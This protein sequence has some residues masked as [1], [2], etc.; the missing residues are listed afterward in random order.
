MTNCNTRG[1][2]TELRFLCIQGLGHS[3]GLSP[4]IREQECLSPK[5]AKPPLRLCV[6][7]N[8][9]FAVDDPGVEISWVTVHL[10][11]LNRYKGTKAH[12]VDCLIA[13]TA[14]AQNVPSRPLIRTF[15]SLATCAWKPNSCKRIAT[16]ARYRK[17]T[18]TFPHSIPNL[19]AKQ[20]KNLQGNLQKH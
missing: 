19:P 3:K 15:E 4:A 9:A 17:R 20:R 18:D 14:V 8:I 2:N 5:S 11:A 6:R 10:D 16:P 12:L 7:A 13:A 1:M